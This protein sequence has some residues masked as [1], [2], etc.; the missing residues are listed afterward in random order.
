MLFILSSVS[1][2]KENNNYEIIKD[3]VTGDEEKNEYIFYSFDYMVKIFK[4][5]QRCPLILY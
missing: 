2:F 5:K 4:D 3:A 1:E